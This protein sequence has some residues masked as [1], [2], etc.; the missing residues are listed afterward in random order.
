MKKQHR[1]LRSALA[2]VLAWGLMVPAGA[3]YADGENTATPPPKF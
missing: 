3:A 1:F 2:A